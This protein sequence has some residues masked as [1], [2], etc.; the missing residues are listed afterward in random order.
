MVG[1]VLNI[2]GAGTIVKYHCD[3]ARTD[4]NLDFLAPRERAAKNCEKTKKK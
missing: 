1:V 2:G 3:A 4:S